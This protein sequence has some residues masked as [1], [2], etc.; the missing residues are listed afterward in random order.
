MFRAC[1]QSVINS[2]YLDRGDLRV[3]KEASFCSNSF[4]SFLL[5]EKVSVDIVSCFEKFFGSLKILF[6]GA[7]RMIEEFLLDLCLDTDFGV[8]CESCEVET[9]RVMNFIGTFL[10]AERDFSEETPEKV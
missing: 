8:Y 6:C 7:S 3:F 4:I 1:V 5:S 10:D 9:I 2:V